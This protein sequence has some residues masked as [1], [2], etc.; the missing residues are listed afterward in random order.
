MLPK[1]NSCATFLHAATALNENECVYTFAHADW[2]CKRG[3]LTTPA[4]PLRQAVRVTRSRR[5]QPRALGGGE[6]AF[7]GDPLESFGRA[8]DPVLAVVTFGRK[9]ADHLIGATRGRTRD[10]AR[11][12][13][14]GRPNWILVHQRPL[15][16]RKTPLRAT[17]PAAKPTGNPTLL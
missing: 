2:F 12:E 14:D 15:H 4:V 8:L 3:L 1:P 10:V 13:I 17:V 7:P 9:L 16:H 5:A 11:G 6:L